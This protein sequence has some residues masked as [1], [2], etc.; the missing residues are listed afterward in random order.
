[1]VCDLATLGVARI[2]LCDPMLFATL[3]VARIA[4]VSR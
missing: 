4:L 2:A 1:M 3:R